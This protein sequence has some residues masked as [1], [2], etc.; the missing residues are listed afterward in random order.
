VAVPL[1]VS[2]LQMLQCKA[3]S[4]S[5]KSLLQKRLQVSLSSVYLFVRIVVSLI[6]NKEK[7][8][9]MAYGKP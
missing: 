9:A 4:M 7:L 3:L 5:G 2:L 1:D 6:L 8:R